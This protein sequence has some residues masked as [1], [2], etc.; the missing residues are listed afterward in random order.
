MQDSN[1]HFTTD[2]FA[3]NKA[4]SHKFKSQLKT[5]ELMPYDKVEK[6]AQSVRTL[7]HETRI[8][9]LKTIAKHGEVNVATIY[10][11]LNM[12]QSLTS[13]HLKAL[14]ECNF[15]MR[16]RDGRNMLYTINREKIQ[17]TMQLLGKKHIHCL[18]PGESDFL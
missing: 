18:Y 13:I 5:S 3:K 14:R 16:I 6:A 11:E 12:E 17:Q 1:F 7:N 9:I 10:K 8:E 2:S 4:F 15:V